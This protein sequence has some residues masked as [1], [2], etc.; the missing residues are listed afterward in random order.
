MI[1]CQQNLYHAQ[2]LQKQVYNKDV[3][4]QS[5]AFDKKV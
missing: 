2:K 3:K 4:P 5:Y 1:I